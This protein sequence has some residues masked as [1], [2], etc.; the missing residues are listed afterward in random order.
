MYATL[1][2]A[3][4][5]VGSAL[6][7]PQSGSASGVTPPKDQ[8]FALAMKV[9]GALVSLNAVS[10]GTANEFVLSAERPSVYPGTPGMWDQDLLCRRLDADSSIAYLNGTG[11]FKALNFDVGG[12]VY[13]ITL[14]TV[15]D[16]YGYA[17]PAFAIADSQQFEWVANDGKIDHERD[18]ALNAFYGRSVEAS[19]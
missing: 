15:G 1:A 19:S 18:A 9:E 5:A 4:A 8:E 11:T 2:L 13:G 6:P 7:A 16:N 3:L 14:P 10:N 17:A 12:K